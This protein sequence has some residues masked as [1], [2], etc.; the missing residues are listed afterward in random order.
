VKDAGDDI[1]ATDKLAIS[2]T[3]K[4]TDDGKVTIRSGEG[5]GVVT[6]WFACSIG[7]LQLINA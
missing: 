4:L 7:K 5:I 1:D 2:A 6:N 3:V